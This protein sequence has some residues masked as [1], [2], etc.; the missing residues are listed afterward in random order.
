M[1]ARERDARVETEIVAA[2]RD[3]SPA[4]DEIHRARLTSGIDAALDEAD[5]VRAARRDETADA[6]RTR[7]RWGLVAVAAVAAFALGIAFRPHGRGAPPPG[8]A[9][10]ARVAVTPPPS[11]PAVQQRA[12]QI[13]DRAPEAL[14]PAT[15]LV[16]LRGER[17]RATVGSRVRL[18]LVGEGR[19]TVLTAARDGDVE[20]ALQA[21]RLLVDYD[22]RAGG[23]LRV[24]SPGALTTVVG[25][26]FAIEVSGAGS[27]VAVAHGVVRTEATSGGRAEVAAGRSWTSS[28]GDLEPISNDLALALTDHEAA[29][30]G[31]AVEPALGRVTE[32]P[33]PSPRR[34]ARPARQPNLDQLYAKAEAAMRDRSTAEARRLLETIVARDPQ[35]PLYEAALLDLARLALTDGDR[36]AALRALGRLP[37]PLRDPALAETADHLRSRAQ[38]PTTR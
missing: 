15:S 27:R 2:L 13:P 1:N 17:T 5:R 32:R 12:E 14:A 26:L 22:G 28:D 30:A 20:L 19:V 38:A 6:P 10:G 9:V 18:T 34:A 7:R 11:Q 31:R 21:G 37:T 35:G 16:A 4:L 29:W 25:T 8:P 36:A 24:R 3:V 33:E 23:T